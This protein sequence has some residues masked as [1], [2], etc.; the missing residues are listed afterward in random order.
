MQSLPFGSPDE[1]LPQTTPL[2][3]SPDKT[4]LTAFAGPIG[5]DK[6]S[7][8]LEA[9]R[10]RFADAM[11]EARTECR[12]EF[13]PAGTQSHHTPRLMSCSSPVTVRRGTINTI[14]LRY[15][16]PNALAL[17]IRHRRRA[18]TS[19]ETAIDVDMDRPSHSVSTCNLSADSAVAAK[20]LRHGIRALSHHN[21]LIPQ[22]VTL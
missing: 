7:T 18:T 21:F 9:G 6:S 22:P 1:N 14:L 12:R 16:R 13:C 4:T 19:K 2:R 3:G 8:R 11:P 20:V 10:V 17:E 15:R 5:R